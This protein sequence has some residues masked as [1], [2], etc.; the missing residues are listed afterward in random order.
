MYLGFSFDILG[1]I[2]MAI[3][4]LEDSGFRI[5]CNIPKAVAK[6]WDHPCVASQTPLPSPNNS[7]MLKQ[8]YEKLAKSAKRKKKRKRNLSYK[9]EQFLNDFCESGDMLFGKVCHLSVSWKRVDACKDP[10]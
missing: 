1:C 5:F 7:S 3:R 10:L 4:I 9:V 2:C 8:L 6:S